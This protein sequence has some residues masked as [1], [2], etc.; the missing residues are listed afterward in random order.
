MAGLLLDYDRLN[1]YVLECGVNWQRVRLLPESY[2][3]ESSRSSSYTKRGYMK[4]FYMYLTEDEVEALDSKAVQTTVCSTLEDV[5]SN[6]K[7]YNVDLPGYVCEVVLVKH[8]EY[9]IKEANIKNK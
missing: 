7:E 6:I 8:V 4:K 3:F 2:W 9:I 1:F 5:R